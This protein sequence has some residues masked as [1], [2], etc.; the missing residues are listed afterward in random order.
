VAQTRLLSVLQSAIAAAKAGDRPAARSLL[1]EVTR[2]EPDNEVA[3]LWLA[4]VAETPDEAVGHLQRVLAINPANERAREGLAHFL[5]RG[6]QASTPAPAAWRCPL[7]QAPAREPQDRCPSCRAVLT[8]A[9]LGAF[10]REGGADQGAVAAAVARLT[11]RLG[12]GADA[13]THR[14][15]GLAYL[16]LRGFDEG[17]RHLQAALRLA[18]D[19]ALQTRVNAL[20]KQR[21][22]LEG[23]RRRPPSRAAHPRT[24]LV[25]DDSPAIRRVVTLALER[26]GHKVSSAS[27]GNEALEKVRAGGVPDLVFLDINMPGPDGYAVCRRL[28]E[29]AGAARVPVVML[30]GRDGFFSK[31]RGRLAGCSGF[32]SKPF[33][34]DDLLGAVEAY[35][36]G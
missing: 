19:E 10:V 9:D 13:D 11:A 6:G 8:L 25:V 29:E 31:V 36:P 18:P 14:W 17:L 21:K 2:G 5:G 22:A 27:D 4:S 26:A 30:S 12:E 24:V 7:C 32:I 3:W 28:R 34:L 1:G 20:R 16:N 33:K 15:L 23:S 35:C